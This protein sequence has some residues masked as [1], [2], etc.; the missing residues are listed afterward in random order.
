MN[1]TREFMRKN[2]E[3]I[4]DLLKAGEM[5]QEAIAQELGVCT[6]TVVR[7]AR[8]HQLRRKDFE[9]PKCVIEPQPEDR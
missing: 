9:S 7:L 4:I 8:K 3:N 6:S 1:S 2:R 5:T